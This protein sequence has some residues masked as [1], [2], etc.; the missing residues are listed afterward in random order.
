VRKLCRIIAKS[1]SID[2]VTSW[3]EGRKFQTLNDALEWLLLEGSLKVPVHQKLLCFAL[4]CFALLCFALRKR[5][6]ELF[7]IFASPCSTTPTTISSSTFKR[8]V[9]ERLVQERLVQERL[10]QE[11]LG[12]WVKKQQQHTHT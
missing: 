2:F 3:G 12:K 10:V 8:L 5:S 1:A 7:E 11:R 9:Q 4:L 6:Q